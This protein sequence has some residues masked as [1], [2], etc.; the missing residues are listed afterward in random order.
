LVTTYTKTLA[1]GLRGAIAM[2]DDKAAARRIEVRTIDGLVRG[3]LRAGQARPV[4]DA[5]ELRGLW[6]QAA[7]AGKLGGQVDFVM[8]EYREII[9]PQGISDFE[10]Y[11]NADRG[12]RAR[13]SETRRWD[14]WRAVSWLR[15]E[16]ARRGE[17]TF[18]GACV[19]VA[20]QLGRAS[21]GEY[22]HV[23]VDEAQDMSAVQWRVIRALVRPGANDIFIA[24][25][26]FQRIYANE[27]DPTSEGVDVSG[28]IHA[29]AVN[30]RSTQEVIA[31]STRLLGSIS[32]RDFVGVE[33]KISASET[34]VVGSAPV[35]QRFGTCEEE[36]EGAARQVRRWLRD[37]VR[38]EEIG[39][40]ARSI[41]GCEY[42]AK[43]LRANGIACMSVGSDRDVRL[44]EV[45]VAT[46]HRMKGL[47]FRCV[48]MVG[49]TSASFP[50]RH[51]TSVFIDQYQHVDET[52]RQRLLLFVAATRARSQLYV[53]WSG[54]PSE[55]LA[56]V[57][58][59]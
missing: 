2:L 54:R 53:S 22:A 30:Y 41:A 3:L 55:F 52:L 17:S 7:Q 10:A 33:E 12:R 5:V 24:G 15:R 19:E 4:V 26:S 57:L 8:K 59:G 21:I 43:F 38:P 25:D 42:I 29:L 31:F 50:H 11:R 36:A 39:V 44:G 37:G 27:V 48:A 9:V 14:L 18:D 16:L 58:S 35:W 34:S 20:R 1:V 23:I 56:P 32:V 46:M 13:L 6:Q 45:V 49:V 28:Q 40:A 47:E 51:V